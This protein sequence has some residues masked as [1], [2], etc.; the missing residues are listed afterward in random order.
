MKAPD[1]P[2]PGASAKP[3][4]NTGIT[5]VIRAARYSSKGVR[6]AWRY[7]SA[8]RQECVGGLVLLPCAI[9]LAESWLQLA[10]LIMVYAIVL[11]AEMLNSALEA[12]VDRIG[13]EHNDLAGR[14]KDMASAAVAFAMAL[15]P[16][17]WVMVALDRFV[18][19]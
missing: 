4:S 17:V 14:A 6:A 9:L 10:L 13:L 18:G 19:Y 15:V 3:S 2:R 8:F 12:A 5:R 11:I 7:E 16:L 1:Q